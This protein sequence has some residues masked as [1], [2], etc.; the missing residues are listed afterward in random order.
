MNSARRLV[1]FSTI[2]LLAS[3]S[4][5][6]PQSPLGRIKPLSNGQAKLTAIE[7]PEFVHE[8]LPYDVILDFSSE[9][10]LSV[11]RVCFKWLSGQSSFSTSSSDCLMGNGQVSSAA[12]TCLSQ[13][14][15]GTNTPGSGIFCVETSNIR[16][17]SP[18]K[19]IVRIRPKDLRPEYNILQA[20]VEYV[21][22]GKLMETNIVETR[23]KVEKPE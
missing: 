12:D 20:Q 14:T 6:Q 13:P 21:T 10:P 15:L 3:C 7:M 11:K 23:V 1:I 8:N 4:A 17:K 16:V 9:G 18:G 5:I 22:K 2:F 19:L